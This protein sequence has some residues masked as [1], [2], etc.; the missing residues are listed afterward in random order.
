[1]DEHFVFQC[2]CV[3]VSEARIRAFYEDDLIGAGAKEA[4]SL[5]ASWLDVKVYDGDTITSGNPIRRFGYSACNSKGELTMRATGGG[6]IGLAVIATAG[7]VINDSFPRN[8]HVYLLMF[9]IGCGLYLKAD[10]DI[11]AKNAQTDSV[12]DPAKDSDG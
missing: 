12:D 2:G 1:M 4:Q 3:K 7:S 9:L 5:P 11:A 8:F 6:L 10:R